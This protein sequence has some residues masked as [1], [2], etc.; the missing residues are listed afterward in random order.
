MNVLFLTMANFRSI[1]ERGIYEDLMRMFVRNRH[2]VLV[3]APAEKRDG[4]N[5]ACIKE[6][7]NFTLLKVKTG[8]LQKASFFKKGIAT[9]K[10]PGQFKKAINKHFRDMKFD[11]ILYST[12]P[13]TLYGAVK[14][15]KRR[16]KAKTFLLLKDIFP[17]N[18]VDIGVLRKNGPKGIIYKY[19]RQKEKK[20]YAVSDYIGC[21]S[22]ANV[23]YILSQN[24]EIDDYKV[25][26]VPNSIEP[27]DVSLTAEEKAQM[28]N[29]Y[30][31]PQDKIVFVYGGNLGKPQGVPFITEC[32]KSQ[33]DNENV[34]FLIVGDGTEYGL[35][36]RYVKTEKLKNV[37]VMQRLP[38]EDFDK[39]VA[40]CDVGL[41]FLDFRFTIPN[42]PSRLL[43]YM[44]AGIP[45]F[46]CTD[47]HTDVG[48]DIVEGGFGWVCASND[49]NGFDTKIREICSSDFAAKGVAAREYLVEN[50]TVA[51]SYKAVMNAIGANE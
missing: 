38:K 21:M 31:I 10:V 40:S 33:K 17:Q 30:E 7:D 35:L 3:V 37:K 23:N 19:F 42:Y 1:S 50:F 45:V 8:N 25:G 11:L 34:F 6:K 5:T 28:R 41:I 39:I 36:E 51:A 15:F 13:I 2:N 27:I 47:P 32:L 12:P 49:I 22:V 43:S 14:Y 16:D 46:A 24:C 4:K 48:K 29:K 20:F 44:Q 9:V 26:I 18:A